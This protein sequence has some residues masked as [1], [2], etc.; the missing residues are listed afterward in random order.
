MRTA[1]LGVQPVL[2]HLLPARLLLLVGSSIVAWCRP[3]AR[4]STSRAWCNA[5]QIA[6]LVN[7]SRAALIHSDAIARV[8]LIK[9]L[10]DQEACASCRAS[11]ATSSTCSPAET[12]ERRTRERANWSPAWARARWWPAA[13]TA[14]TRAVGGLLDR[15]RFLLAA[16]GPQPRHPGGRQTWLIWLAIAGRAVA[17]RR[18]ADRAADQPA[19]QAAVVRRQPRARGRLSTPAGWTRRP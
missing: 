13:S 2:A 8:S 1:R 12:L 17:G 5:R 6:S 16:D 18:G 11:R 9:T 19:A 4:W 7:L 3:S 15:G 14:R 10:A